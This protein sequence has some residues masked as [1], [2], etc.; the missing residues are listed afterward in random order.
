MALVK[1]GTVLLFSSGEYS[2]YSV[3]GAQR[4]LK[5]FC[6]ADVVKGYL[7]YFTKKHEW[8]SPNHYGFMA[9]I[10]RNGYIEDIEDSIEWYMGAYDF[11][12]EI[13]QG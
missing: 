12:P 2:D 8:D 13:N 7:G 9:W 4:V 1:A 10:A 11:Q 5:D 3:S 6:Q